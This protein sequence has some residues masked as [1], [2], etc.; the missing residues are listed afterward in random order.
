MGTRGERTTVRLRVEE[1][2]PRL[3]PGLL[4][5]TPPG[6]V[7]PNVDLI[8]SLPFAPNAGLTN[9]QGHTGGVVHWTPGR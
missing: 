3:T 6:F 1:L 7:D 5:V 2:E 4:T 8:V 9:A